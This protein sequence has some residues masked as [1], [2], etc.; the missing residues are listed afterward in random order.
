L[1]DEAKL[2]LSRHANELTPTEKEFINTS[3]GL[4]HRERANRAIGRFE[5]LVDSSA[6]ELEEEHSVG[7]RE[8][9]RLAKDLP[10][11][12]RPGTWRLQI[13]VIPVP[14]VQS[15]AHASFLP[16]LPIKT[17]LPV[18]SA[19]GTRRFSER[20]FRCSVA[21]DRSGTKA[22]RSDIRTLKSLQLQGASG[23][24]LEVLNPQLDGISDRN[25]RLKFAS[26][27]FDMMHIRGRYADTAEL[28]R[29]E[30][31]LHPP[32]AGIH[33]PRLLPLKIRLIHHQM[34]YRPVTELW[35]EMVDLLTCCD[36][37]QDA[38]S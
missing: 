15:H 27:L 5:L 17:V 18:L 11:L 9:A 34:F 24:A 30:L 29:Q 10:F 20:L 2:W 21:R 19:D 8:T 13:N 6:S 35:S 28:I 14:A 25:A 7:E 26:I 37:T 1:L 36:E 16:C 38:E 23:L 31:A 33:S 4:R 12:A 22:R 3:L 32:N